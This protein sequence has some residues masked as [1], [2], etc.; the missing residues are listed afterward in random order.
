MTGVRRIRS[1]VRRDSRLTRSQARAIEVLWPRYGLEPGYPFDPLVAFGRNAPMT[2][3]IGFGDG[4]NLATL[5]RTFPDEDFL[6]IDVYQPG[7]GAL[8]ARLNRERIENTRLYAADASEILES[9]FPPRVFS[10]VLIFFPDPWPKRRH[11]KR[12]LVQPAFLQQL[13]RVLRPGGQLHLAT[14]DE[15]YAGHMR[16]CLEAAQAYTL[17]SFGADQGSRLRESTRFE[18]RGRRLGHAIYDLVAVRVEH[19]GAQVHDASVE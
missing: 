1:Y 8:L 7:I 11:H 15:H 4:S 17:S 9:A 14:D 6:G 16:A 12:R 13:A 3:E 18:R 2:L 10:R 19:P 5:A